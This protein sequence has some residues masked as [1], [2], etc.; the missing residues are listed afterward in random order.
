METTTLETSTEGRLARN[1]RNVME[2][3]EHLLRSA[4]DTGDQKLESLRTKMQGPLRRMRGQLDAIEETT[5]HR[6]REAA[7]ATDRALHEH[8]YG[9]MAGAALIGFLIGLLITRR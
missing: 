4:A 8:P 2:E 9:A 6:A 3:A 7:R 5:A 1:L